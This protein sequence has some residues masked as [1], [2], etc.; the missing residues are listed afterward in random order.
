MKKW[1]IVLLALAM[2]FAFA[3]CGQQPADPPPADQPADQPADPGPT[4]A[5]TIVIGSTFTLSGAVAH[6]GQKTM[7]GAELAIKYVN[8][9]LGGINGKMLELVYYDDEFDETKIPNLYE[10]LITQDNVD[11]LLSPYT[12]PF[13]AAAPIV[14]KYDKMM[15]CIAADSYVANDEYGQNIVNIQMDDKWRGGMWWHD[16]AEWLVDWESWV[17]EGE[18]EPKTVAVLNL[19]ISYGHEVGDTVIP[20]LEEN[21]YEI[22][23]HEYFEPMAMDYSA[24]VMQLKEL[25]P[26]V[27]FCDF[28]FEDSVALVEAMYQLDYYAPYM[29]IEGMG[30]DPQSWVDPASGGLDPA[31]AEAGIYSYGVYKEL[32]TGADST[33]YLADYCKENYNSI[34]GNDILCG[35]MAVELAAYA[36]M[37]TGGDFSTEALIGALT[38]NTYDLVAYAYTMNETGGNAADFNWGVGQYIPGEGGATGAGDEWYC[39]YP[40]EYATNEATGQF[41]G[42]N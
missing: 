9:E 12:S 29:I 22:V 41:K 8:E 37:D 20:Y 3:A 17:K 13:L 27:V 35:F 7:E 28:Y 21:G 2:V 10:K 18:L 38:S 23:Y 32:Y 25:Q 15:F 30:W 24:V 14:A 6:A 31:I 5:E 4:E 33:K 40:P 36:L 1:F 39:I 26:D 11:I 42:W 16:V 19:E 34:P